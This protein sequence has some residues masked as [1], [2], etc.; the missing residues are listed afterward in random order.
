MSLFVIYTSISCCY[1]MD[2]NNTADL[3]QKVGLTFDTSVA[4][5]AG[6]VSTITPYTKGTEV[7]LQGKLYKNGI[8]I[9]DAKDQA[10]FIFASKQA[11][12][13]ANKSIFQ[14]IRPGQNV[15]MWFQDVRIV[16]APAQKQFGYSIAQINP[17][18]SSFTICNL[19]PPF[20]SCSAFPPVGYSLQP[21]KN[22]NDVTYYIIFPVKDMSD[23]SLAFQFK[24]KF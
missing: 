13:L 10:K 15:V 9:Q 24:L 7:V 18:L 12:K 23:A 16:F 14:G 2:N 6:E 21:T 3:G 19:E 1:A 8:F 22:P 17:L 5:V 20:Q 11:N 4:I